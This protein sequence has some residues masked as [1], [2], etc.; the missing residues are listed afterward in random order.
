MMV[1][2]GSI[3]CT[4]NSI[5]ERGQIV[6]GNA[7]L[8]KF[9]NGEFHPYSIVLTV[10]GKIYGYVMK[11]VKASSCVNS[12]VIV[13]SSGVIG[14]EDVIGGIDNVHC[15]DISGKV[16]GDVSVREKLIIRKGCQISGKITTNGVFFEEGVDRSQFKIGFHDILK[17]EPIFYHL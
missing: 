8:G 7:V 11:N 14:G 15:A 1:T 12:Q 2:A 6:Y 16:L 5:V 9:T 4:K 13:T 17:E 3:I 10:R